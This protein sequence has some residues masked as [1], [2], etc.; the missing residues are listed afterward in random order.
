MGAQGEMRVPK[1]AQSAALGC[2][3]LSSVL[4]ALMGFSPQRK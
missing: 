3:P 4:E 1:G 2:E